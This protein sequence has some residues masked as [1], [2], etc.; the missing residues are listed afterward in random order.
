MISQ[1]IG[2]AAEGTAVDRLITSVT[3]K[4]TTSWIL[5]FAHK[6]S[7]LLTIKQRQLTPG[8]PV[9]VADFT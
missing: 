6:E 5:L 7:G 8:K 3:N 2:D 4:T 1:G 9:E